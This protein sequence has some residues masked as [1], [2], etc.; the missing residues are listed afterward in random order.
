M[1]IVIIANFPANLDGKSYGRFTYLSEMLSEQGHSVEI[2]TSTF[3]HGS[4]KQ[5]RQVTG[6]FKSKITLVYEPGYP[7][8]ISLKRLYSHYCWG[9]SVIKYIKTLKKPDLI[10]VAV[11]SLTVGVKIAEYCKQNCIRMAIDVQDL[12][13]EAFKIVFK[14][15]AFQS[16]FK[17]ME[18]YVNKIYKN[19]DKVIA[20]SNTYLHRALSVNK[21]CQNGLTIYLGN[22]GELFDNSRDKFQI[23]HNQNEIHFAYIGTLG[24]SYDIETILTAIHILKIKNTEIFSQLKFIIM[25]DGPLRSKFEQKTNDLSIA[26]NVEFTGKLPYHEMV[27]KMCSC[28]IVINPIIKNAAQSITNKVGDYAL[29]GLPVINTQE[30][31]EYRDLV[32][33]YRC[34]INCECGNAQNVA[35]AIEKL[36]LDENLRIE[37]GKNHRRLGEERFD[38]RKT[39]QKIIDYITAE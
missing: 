22:N 32:D 3:I 24:Y 9:K 29:S 31:Q 28:D 27:G 12:W 38:R 23:K 25:G 10:Y 4:K 18:W 17:P 30:C 36:C 13:P 39:Y 33:E 34:G 11:P 16:V 37:M 26:S 5:G 6:E 20:V 7:N 14:N 21:K 1:N 8:N 15:K 35:D 19:A 2:I